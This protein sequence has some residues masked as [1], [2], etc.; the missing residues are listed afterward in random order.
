MIR[1]GVRLGRYDMRHDKGPER[2]ALILDA[3]DFEA[4]HGQ[5]FG[6]RIRRRGGFEMV[7]EPVERELHFL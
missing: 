1:I 5:R 3:F 6:D 2:P 4:D 7:F